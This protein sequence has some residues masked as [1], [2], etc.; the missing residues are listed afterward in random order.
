MPENIMPTPMI[1]FVC[2]DK[3]FGKVPEPVPAKKVMPTWYKAMPRTNTVGGTEVRT[4]KR[5]LPFFDVLTTGWVLLLAADTILEIK[6]SGSV[7]S[8]IYIDEGEFKYGPTIEFHHKTQIGDHPAK[9]Q[10]AKFLNPWTIITPPGISCL[11]MP[12]AGQDHNIFS[13]LPAIVD[14]DKYKSPVNLPFLPVSDGKFLLK[15]G[16]PLAQVIPFRREDAAMDSVIRR[17]TTVE[18]I[19]DKVTRN[20]TVDVAGEDIK[21][22]DYYR[23]YVRDSRK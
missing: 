1:E 23:K 8:S 10:P 15:A 2:A 16:E 17:P 14:T 12:P 5:C 6:D 19:A 9:V 11:F 20:Q 18:W 22:A 3:H 7:V 13:V 21:R 4:I